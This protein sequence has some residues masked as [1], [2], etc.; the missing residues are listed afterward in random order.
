MPVVSVSMPTTLIERIDEFADEHDYT[1]RSDA[2]R[3]GTRLLLEEFE[4]DRLEDRP[5]AAVVTALYD[6]GTRDVERE[7][8]RLRHDHEALIVS[9][10]HSHVGEFCMELFVLE[11]AL[12]DVSTFVG[13]VRAIS[14]VSTVD[15]SLLPLDEVGEL[16]G[17]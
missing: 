9:N 4:D 8:T 17:M 6:F 3:E 11:C 1:G 16:E 14:D 15:Y 13:A 7:V 5:L 12:E 2:V 10:T